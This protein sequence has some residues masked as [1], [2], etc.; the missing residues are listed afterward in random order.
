MY[1]VCVCV[2]VLQMCHFLSV[3]L[4]HHEIHIFMYIN[5]T[6]QP[7][8]ALIGCIWSF[9]QNAELYFNIY[10]SQDMLSLKVYLETKLDSSYIILKL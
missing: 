6:Y 3:S 5:D 7:H 10:W 2:I 1:N 8:G 4:E 9:T